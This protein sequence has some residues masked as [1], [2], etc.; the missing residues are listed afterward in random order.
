MSL[1]RA[2]QAYGKEEYEK[3][4]GLA[5]QIPNPT[6]Q[7][8]MCLGK[9]AQALHHFDDCISSFQQVIQMMPELPLGYKVICH[10]FS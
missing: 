2:T 10:P 9:S 8:Y 1:A 3:A 4:W 6:Y 7:V 5:R